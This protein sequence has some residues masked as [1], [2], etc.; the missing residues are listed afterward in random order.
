MTQDAMIDEWYPVGLFSQLDV[1]GRRTA[2]M[3][4]PIEV[5]LNAEGYARVTSGDG[6]TTLP[7]C[8]RYGHVWSSLGK[9]RKD[10]F[11]IPEADQPGRRLVDV[12]VG[13]RALLAA[14]RGRELS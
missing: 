6:R 1:N 14:A 11:A 5:V 10:L 7:V 4:E 2:L 9:P 12:G 8:V 3:G 13:S